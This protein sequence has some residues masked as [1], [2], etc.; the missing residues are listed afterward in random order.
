MRAR[1]KRFFAELRRRKVH[2]TVGAYF[3]LSVMVLEGADL[4]LP[5]IGVTAQTYDVLVILVV[6][7]FPVAMILSWIFDIT[8]AG[9]VRTDRHEVGGAARPPRSD[10]SG[11]EVAKKE[12]TQAHSDVIDSLAILPFDT[13]GDDPDDQYLSEGIAESIINRM[14]RLSGLRVV[15][16]AS[17]FRYNGDNIDLAVVGD[18]L[19]VRAVVT[20]RV[21]QRGD[22]LVVQAELVDVA[23]PS[24]LWGEHYKRPMEDVFDLQEEMATEIYL[25]L[26]QTLNREDKR[27][28]RHRDTEHAEAYQDYL[29][30]RYHWNRRTT[31]GFREATHH[32]RN[33]IGKDPGY[34]LAYAGLADTYNVLGYYSSQAPK[35]SY[36]PAKV[37]AEKALEIDPT[38]AE[39]HASLGYATLFYDREWETAAQHF[40]DAIG[41][42]P[43]YA[44]A[45]QW[46]AWYFL[47]MER[48]EES[49]SQ[50]EEAQRLDPLSLVINDH[51]A[52]AY[53]LSGRIEDVRGQIRK[54]QGL[55]PDYP[56]ALWR[57]GD[58]RVATHELER[59]LVAYE[60][61]V[62]LTQGQLCLGYL[63]LVKGMTGDIEG[64]KAVLG[65][66]DDD[67]GIRYISPL[68][69]A[70]ALAGIGNVDETFDSLER[71]IEERVS[72]VVRIKL[73]PWPDSVRSD[74]R[75]A[76][77]VDR[78]GLPPGSGYPGVVPPSST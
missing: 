78:V 35:E 53:L 18:E 24:Q 29:K 61:A 64:A 67:S 70:L 13:V 72:D 57:L 27:A 69:R 56:L 76:E 11:P 17:A 46:Y 75:F 28:L 49:V 63:G 20:G 33:A 51:L 36:P 10:P 37:A 42:D 4:I 12:G 52:Y 25:A 48:F 47:V 16:R 1:S 74:A 22:T 41:H 40:R 23:G 39:A 65:R 58:Y 6:A 14:S 55:S 77:M 2:R 44:S 32:F 59:A 34:A 31:A 8:G 45:H 5:S 60:R 66:M 15:P 19:H 54:T 9:L 71:A 3:V 68:D 26:S 30:G 7:L 62:D 21:Q 73:L 43:G 50:L 38:L